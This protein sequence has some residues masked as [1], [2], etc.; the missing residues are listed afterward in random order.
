[1]R[2]IRYNSN[3]NNHKSDNET[4]TE[5]KSMICHRQLGG[6]ISARIFVSVSASDNILRA[7]D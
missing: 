3:E 7:T 4:E 2:H 5:N 6:Q 1:M